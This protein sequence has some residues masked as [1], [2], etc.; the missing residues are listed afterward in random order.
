MNRLHLPQLRFGPTRERFLF[1]DWAFGNGR[2]FL[3]TLGL[4]GGWWC[5][6]NLPRN[7]LFEERSSGDVDLLAGPL[8]LSIGAHDFYLMV[9]DARKTSPGAST[10]VHLNAALTRAGTEGLVKWPPEIGYT[11]AV[12]VKAS[13]YDGAHWKAQHIREGGKILGALRKRQELGVN[14]VVF[15][16]LGIVTPTT[17]VDEMERLFADAGRSFPRVFE[18]RDL[19]GAGYYRRLMAG[20][21]RGGNTVWGAEGGGW[22][23]FPEPREFTRQSW[24]ST[25]R[26]RLAKL[27]PPQFLRTF[28][29]GCHACGQWRHSGS[30]NPTGLVCTCGQRH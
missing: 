3:A 28:V 6:L 22:V 25:L 24:H 21:E 20:V 29:V 17:N 23:C 13:H 15:M 11:L 7:E 18:A 26:D 2:D 9:R 27:P 16:H 1:E 5:A 14:D 10:A 4:T 8:G 12:E 19:N 30:A